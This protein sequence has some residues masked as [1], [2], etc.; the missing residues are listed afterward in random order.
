MQDCF[1]KYPEVYGS[2]LADDDEEAAPAED[3]AQALAKTNENQTTASAAPTAAPTEK[4]VPQPAGTKE[5][6]IPRKAVDAT[7]VNKGKK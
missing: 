2:E 3:G 4:A 1:R 5:E 7:D 6:V